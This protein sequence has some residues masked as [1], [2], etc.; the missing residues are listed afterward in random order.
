LRAA[1]GEYRWFLSRAIPIRD[2]SNRIVLWCGTNTDITEQRR[3]TQRLR[4]KARLIELSHEAIFSWDIDG[5]ILTWNRGCEELYGY[6][7]AEAIGAISHELLKSEHP[8]PCQDI[9]AALRA[10]GSWYGEILHY[11]KD[12]TKIWV[13]SRQE[14][15][16]VFGRHI[17]LET[18]RDITERRKS[19]ETRNLLVGELN[20]RVKNTLAIV[21]SV[22]TQTARGSPTIAEFVESFSGRLQS[23]AIAHNVL[24]EA[25]W[26]GADL[27]TLVDS[28]FAVT[29]GSNP[30]VTVRGEDMFIPPQTAL[31]FTLIL[32][33]LVT[34]ALKHGSL[35]VAAGRVD[36]SWN[37]LQ[38]AEP[39]LQ[40][41]WVE[42]AGP[43]VVQPRR[44][45]FGATLIERSGNLPHLKASLHFNP[46]GVECH[47]LA[48]LV[49][50]KRVAP[51]LFDPIR[52]NIPLTAAPRPITQPAPRQARRILVV[53]DEPL[54]AMEIEELLNDSGFVN[55]GPATT[56]TSAMQAISRGAV[57]AVILDGN[58][59]GSPVDDVVDK[60][61]SVGQPFIM[62]TG[63]SRDAIPHRAAG[64]PVLTKPIRQ[65]ELQRA[66]HAVLT[67][68]VD[69]PT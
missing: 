64:V 24:T 28:E 7:Q 19:D 38:G 35:S 4:Q 40:F 48:D 63:Y 60:L 50:D 21:Q 27:R 23:L 12:G 66:L 41:S 54:I 16:K 15:L 1:D 13:D 52:A 26:F 31:H 11:A 68:K 9:M 37:R 8:L 49:E 57:D 61:V 17:V 62:V 45:G 51:T 29:V 47:I 22:A 39:K 44:R 55:A 18:N 56:V 14:V 36:V 25:H 67:Q 43:P 46:G 65:A 3:V 6:T 42:T 53:E 33:E 5:A 2:S 32:H 59:L 10:D 58:L 69:A 30:N 34:N 20:H